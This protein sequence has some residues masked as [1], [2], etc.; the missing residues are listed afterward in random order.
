MSFTGIAKI[1][2]KAVCPAIHIWIFCG[3]MRKNRDGVSNSSVVPIIQK[4]KEL[5]CSADS[6]GENTVSSWMQSLFFGSYFRKKLYFEW[7]SD[8]P[9]EYIIDSL[10]LEVEGKNI[11]SHSQYEEMKGSFEKRCYDL[12]VYDSFLKSCVGYFAVLIGSS[13]KSQYALQNVQGGTIRSEISDLN[14]SLKEMFES[15]CG[16]C[17]PSR[18]LSILHEMQESDL[19]KK[20]LEL[21]EDRTKMSFQDRCY[22]KIVDSIQKDTSKLLEKIFEHKG[23]LALKY[24][25]NS[26]FDL[27]KNLYECVSRCEC[28]SFFDFV[29]S[30]ALSL[31]SGDENSE[32]INK[33]LQEI[34]FLKVIAEAD[35]LRFTDKTHLYRKGL[36]G[37]L[38]G[39]DKLEEICVVVPIASSMIPHFNE[40]KF[41]VDRKKVEK[42]MQAPENG[43]VADD[44]FLGFK[45][46]L[47][48]SVWRKKYKDI[49]D[50][51]LQDDLQFKERLPVP[52]YHYF[53][54]EEA[55][56]KEWVA[57]Q[58]STTFSSLRFVIL[59]T[60]QDA[61]KFVG[62]IR[63]LK[64]LER[65]G[66]I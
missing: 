63:L 58:L 13:K 24:T 39:H 19:E 9:N 17:D 53:V 44:V 34:Y 54:V 7:L 29:Y 45:E 48:S 3:D 36:H 42:F 4:Y 32:K 35:D 57:S 21:F 60:H 50:S 2:F 65:L 31:A 11:N 26:S 28:D 46:C 20:F 59:S 38:C 61:L 49:D 40:E 1:L 6:L 56:A 43:Y 47:K 33:I 62:V 64:D 52:I 37:I 27:R 5:L 8:C 30:T 23:S 55:V 16:I 66:G 41:Y 18:W 12:N 14:E 22:W 25:Y 15:I 51:E 10:L